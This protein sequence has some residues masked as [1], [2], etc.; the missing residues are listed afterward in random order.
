MRVRITINDLNESSKQL[1]LTNTSDHETVFIDIGGMEVL[2][3]IAEL[4]VALRKISVK[5]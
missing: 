2:V 1:E 3:N 4:R 5:E